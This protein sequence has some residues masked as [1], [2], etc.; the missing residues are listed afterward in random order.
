MYIDI[1]TCVCNNGYASQAFKP[2]H[3]MRQGCPILA[4]L[5]V[6]IVKLLATTMCTKPSILGIII[7][8]IQYKISQYA[9]DTCCYLQ[10]ENFLQPALLILELF[11]K[12]AGQSEALSHDA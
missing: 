6:I 3:G 11:R 7:D 4:K 10:D 8:G 1:E 9:D 5:F 12:D 2:R